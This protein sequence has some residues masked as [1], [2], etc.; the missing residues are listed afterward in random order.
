M[1]KFLGS[2]VTVL[3]LFV[4]INAMESPSPQRD[5]L[6]QAIK[7][8]D[9]QTVYQYIANA[10]GD[11]TFFASLDSADNFWLLLATFNEHLDAYY[12]YDLTYRNILLRNMHAVFGY[13]S[14]QDF[15][16]EHNKTSERTATV[17]SEFVEL[18]INI[19]VHAV[20]GCAT[21]YGLE[22]IMRIVISAL[23][24]DEEL[25]RECICIL[26][27]SLHHLRTAIKFGHTGIVK[28]ILDNWIPL[29]LKIDPR[30]SQ[31]HLGYFIGQE[32]LLAA[33]FA[34]KNSKYDAIV[35]SF[36]NNDLIKS[37]LS[38]SDLSY[39][40]NSTENIDRK[41]IIESLLETR[42]S[43]DCKSSKLANQDSQNGLEQ[44]SSS[45]SDDDYGSWVFWS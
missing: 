20:I 16:N 44:I 32:F 37:Y 33:C 29:M 43:A 41:A 12:D 25:A 42:I 19:D 5:E 23:G 45:D 8:R 26:Y 22:E 11:S 36:L 27:Q 13:D 1:K 7:L 3:S 38:L 21:T 24:K 10:D 18:L 34:Q 35:D 31:Q 30:Y 15:Y 40:C 6:E 2:T 9:L 28:I 39:A 17:N 14:L 4:T